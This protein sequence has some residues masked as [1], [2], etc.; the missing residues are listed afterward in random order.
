MFRLAIAGL[1]LAAALW[2]CHAPVVRWVNGWH[3]LGDLAA[4]AV[5]GTIGAAA[6][7]GTV[8]V[9]FGRDWIATFRTKPR[10]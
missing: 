2:V 1:A 3:G 9:L 6:Y 10:G 4:L 8:L 7:G 5:L